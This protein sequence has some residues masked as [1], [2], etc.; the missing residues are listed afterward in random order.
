MKHIV[1][2]FLFILS[3]Y[4]VAYAQD[5]TTSFIARL[6]DSPLFFGIV[7]GSGAVLLVGSLLFL[8]FVK[9][10]EKNAEQ[11]GKGKL[12]ED[13]LLLLESPMASE[14]QAAL[15]YLR[16][17]IQSEDYP[18]LLAALQKQRDAGKINESLLF[19]IKDREVLAAIPLLESIAK[20]KSAVAGMAAD[21]LTELKEIQED[22]KKSDT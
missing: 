16:N 19:L 3:L 14:A 22:E 4:S 8:R 1:S 21:I 17:H 11:W 15:I 10:L 6:F 18:L 7:V 13:V 12:V 5:T 2:V 20:G 9:S